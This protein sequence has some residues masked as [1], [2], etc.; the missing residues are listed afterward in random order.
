MKTLK[1]IARDNQGY[2][3]AVTLT[4]QE[5]QGENAVVKIET[6]PGSWFLSTLWEY[7]PPQIAIDHGQGWM[8]VNIQEILTE[9]RTLVDASAAVRAEEEAWNRLVQGV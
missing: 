6:T 4:P 2:E 9:A 7:K 3:Y 8:C 5:F 1:T